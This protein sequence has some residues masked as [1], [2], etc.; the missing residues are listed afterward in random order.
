MKKSLSLFILLTVNFFLFGQDFALK[1][2]LHPNEKLRSNNYS[3]N[4]EEKLSK[5]NKKFKSNGLVACYPNAKNPE[6]CNVLYN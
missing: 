1:V 4:S 6:H 2:K 5:V 3:I